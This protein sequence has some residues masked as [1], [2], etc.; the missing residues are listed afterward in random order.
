DHWLPISPVTGRLDA[1]VWQAPPD[2]LVAPEL[3]LHDDVTAD[4]DDEPKPLPPVAAPL[5]EAV[6]APEPAPV[7]EPAAP[8][9]P[10]PEPRDDV[11]KDEIKAA[12]SAAEP[13]KEEAPL[14]PPGPVVFPATPPDVPKPKQEAAAR[15]SVFSVW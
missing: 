3:T 6:S 14:P 11:L 8:G 1:F 10:L 2:V 4:L 5:P 7:P 12:L 9:E 13:V 15:R